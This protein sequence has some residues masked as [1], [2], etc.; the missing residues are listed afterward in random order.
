MLTIV[1]FLGFL[2]LFVLIGLASVIYNTH[3]SR[4]YYL[5]SNSVSAWL[6]GLSAVATNNSGYMFIGVIGYTYT[7]GLSAFWVMAGWIS[8]DFIASYIVHRRLREMTT[9][10]GEV[11]YIGVLSNWAGKNMRLYQNLAALVCL[12]L[13]LAYAAAQL[14]AG[15]KALH[16]LFDWP[17]WSG[18]VA[19]ALLVVA[20]CLAGGIR[21]SIWTDAAQSIVMIVAMAILLWVAVA[22]LGG[23]SGAYQQLSAVPDYLNWFPEDMALP[24]AAGAV[25]FALGWLFAG[26]SVAGQ[27]H[28]MVRF[29]TLRDSGEM[30]RARIWYYL[31]FTVFYCMATLVGLLSR[32]YL[33][34]TGSFDAELALPTMALEL[35][36][37]VLVG[38][39]LAGIFAA[40]LSTADSLVLSSSAALSHD[41]LPGKIE[42]PLYI[43]GA[44]L[45]V[46][47]FAMGWA[48]LSAQSVFGMVVMAWSG[49]AS[50]FVPLLLVLILGARPTVATAILM[51]AAGLLTSLLW[52]LFDL[53]NLV[54]EGLSGILAGLLVYALIR[55]LRGGE[56]R[57]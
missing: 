30:K 18:V 55:G 50:S 14:L 34:D 38:L 21:A 15:S 28:I 42:R 27:P 25:L 31:W 8:G 26:F 39:I 44:T 4:D 22:N 1:S 45:L 43:K 54:Y 41:L 48:L 53:H 49:L 47:A 19:G 2:L 16:V 12:V 29:M 6:V 23:V 46:T 35:L 11:S 20:Y 3:H 17:L 32:V 9:E 33:P 40:T 52:R 37:P 10:T 13:L 56:S 5:A 24:G 7:V 57:A 36:P 51:S